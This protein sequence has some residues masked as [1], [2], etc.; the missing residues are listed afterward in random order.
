MRFREFKIAENITLGPAEAKPGAPA[1]KDKIESQGDKNNPLFDPKVLELQKELKAKG[2]DLGSY[3]PNKDGLDGVMG[4]MTR[5][6]A[7]QQ[8]DIAKKYTDV[9]SKP[10]PTAKE[11]DVSIIQDPDFNKKLDNIASNLGVKTSDLLAIMKFESGVNPAAVN[12]MSGATGL[13]QFMPNT[14]SSLGTTTSELAKMTAVEQLD[15]VYRY[16]KMVGLPKGANIQDLYMAV[17]MPVA[18]GKGPDYV[19]GQQG[20]AGFSGKVYAQN[21]GLD[22][23]KDGV[24]TV[25][26]ATQKVQ[27]F[28]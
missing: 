10:N 16:F 1:S 12:K 2:A 4:P 7:G 28:A 17:F 22:A 6:A 5:K 20:A 9:L 23:N 13:I 26:D 3:G 24:I 27:R 21:A 25:A 18:M 19:L 14:A 8:P 11:I 15:Y